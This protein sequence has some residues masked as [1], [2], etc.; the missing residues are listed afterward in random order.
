[1]VFAGRRGAYE[2]RA[3]LLTGRL[4]RLAMG[5]LT[6]LP[7]DAGAFVALGPAARAAVLA[8]PAPSVVAAL[9]A[10]RLRWASVPVERAPRPVGASA[11]TTLDRLRQSARTLAWVAARRARAGRVGRRAGRRSRRGQADQ[12]WT[13][14]SA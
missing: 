11:W 2:S 5:A 14:T 3:R 6:G 4:H 8:D 13:T 7:A 12:R 10:A 9:G 1:M